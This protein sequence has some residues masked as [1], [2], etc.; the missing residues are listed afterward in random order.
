[1]KINIDLGMLYVVYNQRS[2]YGSI[3]WRR[4]RIAGLLNRSSLSKGYEMF[5]VVSC[6]PNLNHKKT[7]EFRL[8]NGVEQQKLAAGN[9]RQREW[10]HQ[11][12]K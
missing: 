10:H 8:C 1:M 9:R 5:V 3:W 11:P 6:A 7:F 4:P 12:G 2:E